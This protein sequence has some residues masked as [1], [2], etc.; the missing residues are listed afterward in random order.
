MTMLVLKI[1]KLRH[2]LILTQMRS[3]NWTVL[4]KT[5]T[6]LESAKI[7]PWIALRNT[8]GVACPLI[9]GL[10]RGQLSAGLI[11]STGA[12]NVSFSD[13]KDPYQQR[14]Q[15]MLLA[16]LFCGLAV[17][18]GSVTG[19]NAISATLVAALWA[20]GAGM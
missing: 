17:I 7:I 13:G 5:V 4:W 9:V 2:T 3:G 20:F 11:M 15:R 18:I 19:R 14:A 12:L 10:L 16:S 8:F 1:R 6:R